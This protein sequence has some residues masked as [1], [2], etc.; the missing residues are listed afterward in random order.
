MQLNV[1]VGWPRLSHTLLLC[2]LLS[3][4]SRM[5]ESREKHCCK[6]SSLS[7][8]GGGKRKGSHLPADQCLANLQAAAALE[9]HPPQF[10]WCYITWCGVFLQS[11]Q[12]SCPGC[13]PSHSFAQPQMTAGVVEQETEKA[14][15]LCNHCSA[16]GKALCYQNC[17]GCRSKTQHLAGC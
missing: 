14:L 2:C 6:C 16:T 3:P 12:V 1:A 5:G 15:T 10:Y 9:P 7:K 8:E 17:S 11:V 13:V 4:C